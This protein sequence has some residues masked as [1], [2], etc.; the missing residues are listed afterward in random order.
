MNIF[1]AKQDGWVKFMEDDKVKDS[2]THLIFLPAAL[3]LFVLTGCSSV[4]STKEPSVS[5]VVAQVT[6]DDNSAPQPSSALPR[7]PINRLSARS[8]SIWVS[9]LTVR[10]P[11]PQGV[12]AQASQ[13]EE[14]PVVVSARLSQRSEPATKK[15]ERPKAASLSRRTAS[16]DDRLKAVLSGR[17][18]S[19]ES[20]VND[21]LV[22]VIAA[23][24]IADD[25]TDEES[26]TK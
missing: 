6:T 2:K 25:N 18:P 1:R 8:S 16:V 10:E 14:R 7:R 24:E 5:D 21:A 26:S 19:G 9:H 12:Q 17:N 23:T 4:K 13:P 20:T 11:I 15:P 3:A 22:E